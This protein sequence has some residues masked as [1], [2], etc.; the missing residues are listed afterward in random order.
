MVLEKFPIEYLYYS[1]LV[2][3]NQFSIKISVSI[4]LLSEG[5]GGGDWKPANKKC[6]SVM[7][8]HVTEY[9]L[10]IISL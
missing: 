3:I 10:Q 2:I 7:T 9:C 5:Q 8:E 6:Y 4:Q 1:V